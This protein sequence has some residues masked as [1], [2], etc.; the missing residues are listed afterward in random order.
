MKPLVLAEARIDGL[1]E[2]IKS[3]HA[4]SA[5]GTALGMLA[6]G[7]SAAHAVSRRSSPRGLAGSASAA[8]LAIVVLNYAGKKRDLDVQDELRK[9][10]YAHDFGE[11]SEQRALRSLALRDIRGLMERGITSSTPSGRTVHV[12]L[13]SL[14]YCID[15]GAAK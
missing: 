6:L 12:R 13:N 4:S 2:I 9:L 11:G 15:S 3:R 10:I 1:A 7:A 14:V 8:V 5:Q